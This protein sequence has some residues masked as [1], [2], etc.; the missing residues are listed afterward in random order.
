MKAS[1]L[2]PKNSGWIQKTR[3]LLLDRFSHD[4]SL[5]MPTVSRHRKDFWRAWLCIFFHVVDC[6]LSK[7]SSSSLP[8]LVEQITSKDSEQGWKLEEVLPSSRGK[9]CTIAIRHHKEHD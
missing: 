2:V 1:K 8:F 9:E 6:Y 7:A 4:S 3:T 5:E